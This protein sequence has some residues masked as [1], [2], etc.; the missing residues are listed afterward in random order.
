VTSQTEWSSSDQKLL[1]VVVFMFNSTFRYQHTFMVTFEEILEE[2]HKAFKAH[3]HATKEHRKVEEAQELQEFLACFKKERQ[4]KVTQV[5][6]VVLPSNYG[7]AKVMPDVSTSSPSVTPEDVI[8]MLND[9]TELL[10]NLLHYMLEDSLVKIFK[11]LNPSSDP[12][13]VSGIPQ[14]LSYLAQHETLE[15]PLY[16]MSTNFTPSQAPPIMSTLPSRPKTAM[17]IS[18]PVVEPLNSIP[19]SATMSRTNELANFVPPYQT[20]A[21]RTHPIPPR[22]M[23]VPHGLMPD[24][25]FNKYGTPDR[26]PRTKPRGLH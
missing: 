24:Y 11:T 22:G 19:S 6:E 14:T 13:G 1:H 5:K 26:V 15:N 16:S 3:R 10:T 9:H 20:V 8:G 4:D 21:Y 12:N 18:P 17:V 23:G 2:Q 7:K 25:Y